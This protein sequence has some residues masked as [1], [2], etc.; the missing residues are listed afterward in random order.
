MELILIVFVLGSSVPVTFTFWAG[1][2]AG[3][4]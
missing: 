3:L 4:V 2:F 1:N